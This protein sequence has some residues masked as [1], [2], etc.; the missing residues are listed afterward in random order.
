MHITTFAVTGEEPEPP[1]TRSPFFAPYE[2]YNADG[3]LV[4]VG[5]GGKAAWERLCSS[6]GLEQLADDSRF[7]DNSS[8]VANAEELRH[9]I[10]AVLRRAPTEHWEQIF[11]DAEI[12]HAPVQKLAQVLASEQVQALGAL[13]ELDHPA[14]GAVPIVRLPIRFSVQPRP[15][16]PRHPGSARAPTSA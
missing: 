10:E 11:R 13:S 5:T 2:A 1:G 12:P 7:A 8:R 9:E 14:A 4:V 6:L 3:Y 15:P 16:P